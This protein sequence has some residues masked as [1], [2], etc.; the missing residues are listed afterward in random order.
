MN[1]DIDNFINYK[2]EYNKFRKTNIT[3]RNDLVERDEKI[4]ELKNKIKKIR[5]LRNNNCYY[6]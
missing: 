1:T 4:I 5:E 3:L 2:K 6:C